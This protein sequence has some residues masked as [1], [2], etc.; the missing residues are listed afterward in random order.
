MFERDASCFDGE[1][2]ELVV[3]HLLGALVTVCT[4]GIC[5][6]WAYCKIYRWEA[7]HTVINEHRLSFDGTAMQLL[8]NW[9]KW[10]LLTIITLGIY[11]FWVGIKLKQWKI[12]HTH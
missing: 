11:S 4:L 8:G 9:I 10:L 1:L 2:G 3:L 5:F 12:M 6:P 7:S